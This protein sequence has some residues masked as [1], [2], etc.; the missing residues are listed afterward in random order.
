AQPG[1]QQLELFLY[2]VDVPEALGPPHLVPHGRA[3]DLAVKPNWYPR[4]DGADPEDGFVSTTGRP[5]L[6]AAEQSAAGPA[7]TVVAFSPGTLHRG[8]G[9]TAHRG[10]RYTM[11]LSYRPARADWAQRAG[12]A[13][14]S[15]DPAWYHLVRQ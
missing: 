12:W 10:A 9:L 7:G 4:T 1:C 15:H 8:T 6:Y 13:D 5:D 14:R 2:L 11:H 3:A